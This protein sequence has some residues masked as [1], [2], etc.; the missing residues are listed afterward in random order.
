MTTLVLS[1]Y[2]GLTSFLK[3]K[4]K[5]IKA[6]MFLNVCQIQQPTTELAALEKIYRRAM[7][8]NWSNQKANSALKTKNR[9]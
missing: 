1:F 3:V 6:W 9:K 4:M 8:R 5:T 2:N 7:N